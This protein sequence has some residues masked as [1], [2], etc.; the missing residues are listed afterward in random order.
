[1]SGNVLASIPEGN[2]VSVLI[3]VLMVVTCIGGYPLYMGPIHVVVESGMGV[4][5]TNAYFITSKKFIVFRV[6]EILLISLVA[7]LLPFFSDILSF[8]ILL[9]LM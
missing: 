5:T 4:P 8:N 3:S 6:V 7:T 1:M 9:W 2:W